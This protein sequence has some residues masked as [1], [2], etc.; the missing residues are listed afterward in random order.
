MKKYRDVDEFIAGQEY[1]QEELILLREIVIA[2]PMQETIKWNFPVYTVKGKNVVGLGAFKSYF[3]IWFYQGAL[4]TDAGKKLINAQEGK[5][6][7]MRQWR[8]QSSSDIEAPLIKTYLA[9]AIDNQLAGRVVKTSP[10]GKKPLSLPPLLKEALEN[11][12]GALHAF[13]ALTLSRK[14]DYAE[15]IDTAKRDATKMKRLEKIIPMIL[16]GKGL[17]DQYQ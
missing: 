12:E 9:E 2:M 6:Q 10:P 4:L 14:R 1:W 15:Y 5:T 7:A 11:T 16:Q 17:N 13:G 8:F 3:G